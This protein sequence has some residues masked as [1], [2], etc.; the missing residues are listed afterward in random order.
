M[1]APKVSGTKYTN[2]DK[3]M[4]MAVVQRNSEK[5]NGGKKESNDYSWRIKIYKKRGATVRRQKTENEGRRKEEKRPLKSAQRTTQRE[6]KQ[7][8]KGNSH[9]QKRDHPSGPGG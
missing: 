8:K 6:I 4:L 1:K 9:E 5:K 2:R 7:H 3:P